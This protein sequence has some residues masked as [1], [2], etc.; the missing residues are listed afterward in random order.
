MTL[1]YWIVINYIRM[2]SWAHCKYHECINN[3]DRLLQRDFVAMQCVK[4]SIKLNSN[5][6]LF[7]R[8]TWEKKTS[9]HTMHHSAVTYMLTLGTLGCKLEKNERYKIANI[10]PCGK[11]C[12]Q[13]HPIFHV[14][15]SAQSDSGSSEWQCCLAVQIWIMPHTVYKQANTPVH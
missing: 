11:K 5:I 9:L 3:T 12:S 2:L 13:A 7:K 8:Q 14:Y 6:Y 15:I 1:Y 10:E 4:C